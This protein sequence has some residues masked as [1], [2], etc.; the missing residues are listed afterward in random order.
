MSGGSLI[1]GGVFAGIGL[2]SLIPLF[3]V[4][5]VVANR[6]EPDP[7]GLRPSSVYLFGMSFVTLM[8]GYGGAVMIVTSLL[9]FIGPHSSPIA[10][11]VASNVVIGALFVAIAGGTFA[12]HVRKGITIARGDGRVDGPNNRILHT[13]VSVVSFIFVAV[14]IITLGFAVYSLFQ[15][16]GPGIFGSLGGSRTGTLRD[17]L[18]E[19]YVMVASGAIV[20]AHSRLLPD[21]FLFRSPSP[22]VASSM[23]A[24]P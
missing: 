4:I 18:D 24:Q 21:G 2:L 13:Y 23:P 10:N 14:A 6:A 11:G 17:L 1:F 5:V 15:E 8:F 20:V 19:V 12:V 16:I 7:R 3:F 9:S 22:A